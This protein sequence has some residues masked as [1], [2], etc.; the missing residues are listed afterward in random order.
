LKPFE[1]LLL[2]FYKLLLGCR[3]LMYNKDGIN[4][5][6]ITNVSGGNREMTP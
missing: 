5:E 6:V 3:F 2:E 1:A 4:K